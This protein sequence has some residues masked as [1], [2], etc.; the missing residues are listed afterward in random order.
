M[1]IS[2]LSVLPYESYSVS[3]HSYPSKDLTA[4]SRHHI[5]NS[6]DS[7]VNINS[8]VAIILEWSMLAPHSSRIQILLILSISIRFIVEKKNISST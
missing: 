1:D 8:N 5:L 3:R 6:V 7:N 4:K 2:K